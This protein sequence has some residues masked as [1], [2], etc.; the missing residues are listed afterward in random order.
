MQKQLLFVDD[1]PFVL[2]AF[3]RSLMSYRSS[4]AMSFVDSPLD[5][6]QRVTTSPIDLVVSDMTMPGMDGLELLGRMQAQDDTRDIPFIIVT[7]RGEHGLRRRSLE[8]GATDLLEKPVD[9]DELVAR[10]RNALRLKSAQDELKSQNELLEQR[11]R[12]RTA[13]LE[14]SRLEVIRR[15]A[16][17]AEFRDEE[18]GNHVIRVGLYSRLI[19]EALGFDFEFVESLGLAV[20]LHDI[21]KIGIPDAILLKPGRLTEDEFKIMQGHC[22]IGARILLQEPEAAR[23][24]QEPDAAWFAEVTRPSDRSTL[25]LAAAIALTHHEKWNGSGY[26][27][28]LAGDE[29]PIEGRIVAICD[30]FDALMSQRPT[31]C[32]FTEEETVAILAQEAGRHFDPAVHVAFVSVLDRLRSVREAFSDQ[33][34]HSAELCKSS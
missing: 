31:S 21:G 32:A 28:G 10:I 24:S 6:W 22:L 7:G 3:R 29:I 25:R 20:P 23:V 19:A 27:R 11:V 18:T 17:A 4:W 16:K 1:E 5:A 13:E 26:P 14:A 12:E 9:P 34:C 30:V 33:I 2:D 8:L 15:L